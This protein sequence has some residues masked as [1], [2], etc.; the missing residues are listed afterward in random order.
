MKGTVLSSSIII[1]A[2]LNDNTAV[3]GRVTQTFPVVAAAEAQLPYISYRRTGL[4]TVAA[5][6]AVSADTATV[7]VNCYTAGYGDGVELAEAVRTALDGR[8]C[9][10]GGMVMRGCTMVGAQEGWTDDAFVQ[11]LVFEVKI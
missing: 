2:L 1:G 5:K 6:G 11:T 10:I 9:R 3:A 7:E 4:G 8:S